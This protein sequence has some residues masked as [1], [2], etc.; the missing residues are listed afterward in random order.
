MKIK[1]LGH[2]CLIVEPKD[3]IRIM[4]DP[5]SFSTTQTQEKDISAVVITHEHADH[6]HIDSLKKVLENNPNAIV[7]T[8]TAVGKLLKEVDIPFIKVEEGES[9]D[10]DGIQ[11]SGFGNTHA[12]IYGDYGQVQNTGYMIDNLCYPG[13][14]FHMP[15]IDVDILALPVAGPWMRIKDAIDYGKKVKPRIAF[16]VH[17][18]ILSEVATFVPKITGYFLREDGIEFKILEIGKEEEV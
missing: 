12:E 6:L 15:N 14:A 10:L 5:G 1:K 8:N 2:C 9:Y 11:I 13:D 17:D 4:T 7:I 18:A 3:D 16:P